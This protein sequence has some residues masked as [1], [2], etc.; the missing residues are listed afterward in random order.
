MSKMALLIIDM[1]MAMLDRIE[2]GR[3]AVNPDAGAAIERLAAACRENGVAVVHIRHHEADPASPFHPDAPLARPMPCDAAQPGEAV[4]IKHTSSAFASTD[5]A[6]HLRGAGVTR[7]IV[8]GAVLGFCVTS[9][10][11]AASDL[12]FEVILPRDAVLGF[13]LPFMGLGAEEIAKV[14][15]GLLGADFATLSSVAEVVASF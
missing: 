3:A 9:T 14:T 13:D 11:R 4:F 7:L 2:A 8:T 1:Q 10:V 6:A 15:F 12:G 5:L